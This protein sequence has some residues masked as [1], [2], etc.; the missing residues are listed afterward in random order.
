MFQL[1]GPILLI[2]VAAVVAVILF[3][4]FFIAERKREHGPKEIDG[5]NP[6]L[7]DERTMFNALG[8]AVIVVNAQ[9][10]IL[11]MNRAAEDLIGLDV[12]SA[13]GL[14]YQTILK[15]RSS[16]DQPI[17]ITQDAFAQAVAS[18]GRFSVDNLSIINTKKQKLSVSI[19]ATPIQNSKGEVQGAIAVLHDTTSQ[20]ALVRERDEFIST[21]SHEMRTPLAAIEGYISM[22]QNP[23]LSTIDERAKGFLGKAHQAS[24]HLGQLFSDLLSVSKIDDKRVNEH[25]EIF[26]LSEILLAT[27][28]EM[29]VLAQ[30]KN[31]NL[32]L[33]IGSASAPGGVVV[34]PAYN[35]YADKDRIR[36]I[37]SNLIDNAIKYTRQGSINVSIMDNAGSVVVEVADTGIGIAAP[38]QKHIFEKFYRANNSFTREINGNGLGLYIV[39]NL[40]EHYGGRVWV[41]SEENKGST[42]G[43]SLPLAR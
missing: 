17:T 33:K 27:I 4:I 1:S 34:A 22:A 40:V 12:E 21:A 32:N 8:D 26:N 3:V 31:L 14:N 37:L 19:V 35:V 5:H 15:L 7:F 6:V 29:R 24:L 11:F 41:K 10:A 43:F 36:E 20:Q 9:R 23:Q 39:R 30:Q 16:E 28:D 2:S 38:D 25:V 18:G 42:F 13:R